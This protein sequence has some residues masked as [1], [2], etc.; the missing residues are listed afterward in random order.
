MATK[1]LP[2]PDVLRQLLR[3]EPETGKLFWKVRDRAWFPSGRAHS[4]WNARYAGAEAFIKKESF[5]HL[6]GCVLGK[7]YKA[8]RVIWVIVHGEEPAG[9]ID[10]VNRDP[11]DNRAN[12]LRIATYQ[13]NSFNSTKR[14][15]A[16]S[17][18]RGVYFHRVTGKWA[19]TIRDGS[20]HRHLGL[21]DTEERAAM[22]YDSIAV[23][24]HGDFASMNNV[25]ERQAMKEPV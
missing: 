20:T 11:G 7:L 21:F 19:A 6:V 12:N 25:A 17:K 23:N 10:H 22:A 15:G 8:H 18:F 3:Y 24:A 5:G 2:S 13:Q 16:T 4:S 14:R 1:P 9:M